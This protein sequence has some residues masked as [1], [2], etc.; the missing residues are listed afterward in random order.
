MPNI[1]LSPQAPASAGTFYDIASEFP[2]D[3]L[4]TLMLWINYPWMFP[5]GVNRLPLPNDPVSPA[6]GG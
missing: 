1:V 2:R 3:P 6:I 5:G 4:K